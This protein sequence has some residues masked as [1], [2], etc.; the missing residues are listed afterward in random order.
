MLKVLASDKRTSLF[1]N[2]IIS[3]EE[4][5]LTSGAN[6]IKLFTAASCDFS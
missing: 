5:L 4:K 2:S 3:G 1:C 6:D